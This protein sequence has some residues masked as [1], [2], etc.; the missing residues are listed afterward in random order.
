[1]TRIKFFMFI[2]YTALVFAAGFYSAM[3]GDSG[4]FSKKDVVKT[5]A[6]KEKVIP[7]FKPINSQLHKPNNSLPTFTNDD[8]NRDVIKHYRRT[9]KDGNYTEK[10]LRVLKQKD[11][12]NLTIKSEK[13]EKADEGKEEKDGVNAFFD[14]LSKKAGNLVEKAKKLTLQPEFKDNPAIKEMMK[15]NPAELKDLI[16]NGMKRRNE[17]LKQIESEM[18]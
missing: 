11:G 12:G 4:F 15:K 9:K 17:A 7:S 13:K 6:K 10:D 5:P 2:V 18:E 8:I 1:M 16:Q 3:Q 14:E